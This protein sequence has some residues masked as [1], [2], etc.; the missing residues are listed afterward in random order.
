MCS[1]GHFANYDKLW[2]SHYCPT[3]FWDSCITALNQHPGTYSWVEISTLY[4]HPRPRGTCIMQNVL[5]RIDSLAVGRS[6][7]DTLHR[8]S[9]LRILSSIFYA[10]L[11]DKPE[12]LTVRIIILE[13]YYWHFLWCYKLLSTPEP[14]EPSWNMLSNSKWEVMLNIV[15]WFITL[16]RLY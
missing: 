2:R 16:L 11:W 3:S 15:L 12:S 10:G 4:H 1:C 14:C 7:G 13:Y 6:A 5:V 8:S 9:F